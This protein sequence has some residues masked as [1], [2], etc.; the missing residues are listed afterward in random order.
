MTTHVEAVD[1]MYGIFNSVWGSG[2]SPIVGYLPIVEFDDVPIDSLDSLTDVFARVTSTDTAGRQITM[3]QGAER[4]TLGIMIIRVFTPKH[5]SYVGIGRQL[6]Q[7]VQKAF[8]A[9][10][11]SGPVIYKNVYV[12]TPSPDDR[13]RQFVVFVDYEYTQT[14]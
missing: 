3:G 1:A 11:A 2:A 12:S 14:I 13:W 5:V 10:G 4:E 8:T 6:G 9:A 7:L